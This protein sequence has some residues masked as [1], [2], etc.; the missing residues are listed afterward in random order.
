MDAMKF[1]STMTDIDGIWDTLSPD[2][3]DAVLTEHREF[4]KAL[5]QAGKFVDAF[6]LYPRQTA[7][8]VRRDNAGSVTV[9]DGP[10][11][12]AAE[13]MGGCYVIEAESVD[14]AVEWA[15]ECRFI[16][17]ANEVRQVWE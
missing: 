16:E 14:E 7:R 1:L 12:Q 17:G 8:T 4:R 6:H 3:Q 10:C 5:H 2:K 9:I 11:Q 15:R 13:Y